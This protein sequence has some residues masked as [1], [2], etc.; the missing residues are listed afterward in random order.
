[1]REANNHPTLNVL[2]LK[3]KVIT[4]SSF[5]TMVTVFVGKQLSV[6]SILNTKLHKIMHQTFI[7]EYTIE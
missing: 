6:Y 4:N 3:K 2:E 5:T 7:N 1:M